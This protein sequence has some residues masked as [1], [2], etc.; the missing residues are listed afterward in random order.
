[1]EYIV[2]RVNTIA[3]L[4][5]VPTGY[6]VE[7]DV[8]DD[9]TGRIYMQHD[10]FTDGEDFEDYLK[11]FHHGTMIIN[12]KSE[13]IE[14]KV[15]KLLAAYPVQRYFFLDSSFPM[16]KLLSDLGE[17]SL[18][19]RFSEYEGMDTLEAMAGRAEWVWVDTFQK[20]PLHAGV[21]GR[22]REL[23]Y[24]VCLVSPELQGQPEKLAPYAQQLRREGILPDAVCCKAYQIAKWERYL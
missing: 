5:E 14:H 7:L 1:M 22:M 11:A 21:F 20:L 18:A 23:G 24:K 8:R 12:V 13:R 6:G 16:I 9:L 19:V 10:P 2:H 3:E 4:K 17:H 15:L